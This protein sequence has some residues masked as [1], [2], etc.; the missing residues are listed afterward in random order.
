MTF[1]LYIALGFAIGISIL[2]YGLRRKKK[3]LIIASWIILA[4]LVFGV[5][6]L[7]NGLSNM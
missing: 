2:L 3:V 6:I 7:A 1:S 5:V 4:L